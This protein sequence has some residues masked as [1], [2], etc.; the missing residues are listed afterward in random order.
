MNNSTLIEDSD[1]TPKNMELLRIKE[2]K[3]TTLIETINR[4]ASSDDWCTLKKELF[5]GN[6]ATI[7][8]R[9][10]TEANK[11]KIDDS[12]IYRLQGQMAWARTYAHLEK[13]SERFR[14]EIANIRKQLYGKRTE[15]GASN[16][17]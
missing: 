15:D 5:D 11:A 12:E 7:E 17:S 2:G 3:L 1:I 14:V 10:I 4:V 6:L 16:R 13:L 8:K 9:L